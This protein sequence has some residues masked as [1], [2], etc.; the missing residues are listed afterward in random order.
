MRLSELIKSIE[1]KEQRNFT[2]AEI[3]GISADSRQIGRNGLFVAVKG[4]QSD[5]LK[6]VEAA[7]KNGAVACVSEMPIDSDQITNVVVE[8]SARALALLAAAF[9][10]N[11]AAALVNCG[12]TGT[13]GKTSTAHLLRAIVQSAD[14]GKIRHQRENVDGPSAAGDRAVG[15]LGENGNHRYHRPWGRTKTR[16]R[17]THHARTGHPAP[18]ASENKEF[19]LSR[20]GHGGQ[21]TCGA[22]ATN[23]GN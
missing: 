20:G 3:S 12:V 14:W 16:N 8:D 10:G 1:S 18:A 15:R 22:A 7:R 4:T 5:G 23:R 2:D 11:P 19:W 6:Y 21:F 9:F 17:F 13:N